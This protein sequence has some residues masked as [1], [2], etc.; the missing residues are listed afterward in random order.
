MNKEIT[1]PKGAHFLSD[2]MEVLPDH[3]LFNK[4][5]TGCGGTTVE[6]R[7]KH[8]SVI[9]VPTRNLAI[10]KASDVVFPFI[11]GTLDQ[12]LNDYLMSD[13]EYKKIITT[14]DRL[15]TVAARVDIQNWTLLIDEYHLLFNDYSFRSDAI[16][17][18]LRCYLKFP[19]WCFM[20][21]TPI[22]REFILQEL[23]GIDELSIKW[24]D[25]IDVAIQIEDTAQVVKRLLQIMNRSKHNLHIFLNSVNTIKY[26]VEKMDITDYRVVCSGKNASKVT[27]YALPTSPV[28]KYNFYTSCAFEGVDIFDPDGETVIVSDTNICTTL[29]DISTKVRQICGRIRDSRH[30]DRCLFIVNTRKHRYANVSRPIFDNRVVQSERL[31]KRKQEL[32][33]TVFDEELMKAECIVYNENFTTLYLNKYRDNVF[34]DPNLKTIDEYNYRLVSEIY[35]SQVKVL[36]E[37][38]AQEHIKAEGCTLI[39]DNRGLQWIRE[40]LSKQTQQDYTYEELEEI[41]KPMFKEHD[42]R[43]SSNNSIKLYFPKHKKYRRRTKGALYT[44]YKF[45]LL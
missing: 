32:Y 38:N 28:K 25:A 21:A 9:A 43:W 29:V 8:N 23:D 39:M 31:G 4:S 44:V 22:S 24:P 30:K 36:A 34:Y 18:V 41:F 42:M 45:F 16:Q 11:G 10:S 37:C 33:S 3:C 14:Y 15:P 6:I 35:T 40:W 17:G 20:T 26:I 13:V 12:A 27:G 2:F 5:I 7:A 19:H 1:A